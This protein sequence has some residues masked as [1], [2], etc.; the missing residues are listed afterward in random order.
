[1]VDRKSRDGKDAAGLKLAVLARV[2]AE[3]EAAG[4]KTAVAELGGMLDNAETIEDAK[5][6]LLRYSFRVLVPTVRRG[7]T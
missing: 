5:N 3:G 4:K 7:P 6:E 1:M 2:F